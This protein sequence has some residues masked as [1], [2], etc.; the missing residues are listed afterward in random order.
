MPGIRWDEEDVS[1]SLIFFP[2]VGAV[3][4]ALIF[5]LNGV[6]PLSSLHPALRIIL[7]VLIPLL[8]TGGVHIDGLMDTEDALNSF[9]STERKLE[10]L[11]DPHTGAF[12]VISLIKWMLISAAAVTAIIVDRKTDLR[13]LM[14]MGLIFV[15]SRGLSGLTSLF[16][17]GAKKEGMLYRE[18]KG[19]K[20]LVTVCLLLELLAAGGVALY[21]HVLYGGAVL[22]AF[23]LFTL[24]YRRMTYREFGGVTGDT[25][26]YFVTAGEAVALAVLAIAVMGAPA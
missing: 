21:F 22:I 5:I 25:A 6:E 8:I 4:G 15:I 20:R 14:I 18:T 2:F 17:K 13:V 11:K 23:G 19:D 9:S 12:A 3:I 26:G 16:F 24:Y 10:I 7:T 1:H